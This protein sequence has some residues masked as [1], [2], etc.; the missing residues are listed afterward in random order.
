MSEEKDIY[1]AIVGTA[2]R[3]ID[4][5][6]I[7]L[8]LF[9]CMAKCSEFIIENVFKLDK[10]KIHLVSGGAPCADAVAVDL[11]LNDKFP[12]LTVYIPA[13]LDKNK[14]EFVDLGK[15]AHWSLNT[16]PRSNY[17]HRQFSSYVYSGDAKHS[18]RDLISVSSKPNGILDNSSI[19]FK[20]RNLDIAKVNYL[21]A[22][23]WGEDPA[24][25]KDG[26]T[27]HTFDH[28]KGQ[29]VHV[30]LNWL[31]NLLIKK[32]IKEE[33]ENK[34]IEDYQVLFK[35]LSF[36]VSKIKETK[37]EPKLKSQ[38]IE[39]F[40]SSSTPLKDSSSFLLIQKNRKRSREENDTEDTK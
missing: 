40:F 16:G 32:Q 22:F 38:P 15:Q 5:N 36:H 27:K 4:A 11:F 25:P 13:S 18:L 9:N 34:E 8:S 30:P 1:V 20:K 2:G 26:G 24:V 29:R 35:D 6:K 37:P 21:I 3:G 7:N 33:K 12:K 19:G 14:N 31:L 23:T 28:S 39:K 10:Q 17:L